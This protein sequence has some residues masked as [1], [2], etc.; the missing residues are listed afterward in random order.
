MITSGKVRM[1]QGA[2]D[3]TVLLYHQ[4]NNTFYAIQPSQ[5]S[6]MELDPVKAGEMMDQASQMQ[7][8]MMAQLEERMKD[9]PEAQRTQMMEMMK[10][11][12]QQMPGL[13]EEPIRYE[14][15]GGSDSVARGR[16]E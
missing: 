12:G 3:D 9:M 16:G 1:E 15:R 13:Q 6:Y 7:Q 14:E 2:T 5:K 4:S 10:R 8:Q 11:S